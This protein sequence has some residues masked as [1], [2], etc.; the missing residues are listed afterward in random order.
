[1]IA[2]FIQVRTRINN[3]FV[4]I[5]GSLIFSTNIF[6]A[7]LRLNDNELICMEIYFNQNEIPQEKP[8]QK[9]LMKL[10]VLSKQFL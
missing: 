4:W 5:K 8:Q 6:F 2:E 7:F 9:Y 10:K 3:K 1:M